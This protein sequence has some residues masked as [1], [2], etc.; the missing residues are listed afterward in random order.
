MNKLYARFAIF[1]FAFCLIFKFGWALLLALVF[2]F[3]AAIDSIFLPLSLAFALFAV[4]AA[5][6]EAGKLIHYMRK[7]KDDV[8]KTMKDIETNP[9]AYYDP[10]NPNCIRGRTWVMKLKEI[11]HDGSSV[12]EVVAAFEDL[13]EDMKFDGILTG[14]VTAG[15]SDEELLARD[16]LM[17]ECG[18]FHCIDN[19]FTIALT[20]QYP[21]GEGEFFQFRVEMHFEPNKENYKIFEHMNSDKVRGDFFDYIRGSKSYRYAEKHACRSVQ[22]YLTQT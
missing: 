4:I 8:A 15:L 10:D 1:H 16:L 12:E 20:R 17:F 3:L 2:L 5:A 14:R 9:E 6:I 21:D 22:I 11:L 7:N 18:T 13:C 19:D